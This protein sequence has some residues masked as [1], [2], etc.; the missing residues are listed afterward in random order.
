MALLFTATIA[1]REPSFQARRWQHRGGAA[2][3][4]R[5]DQRYPGAAAT[6][7]GPGAGGGAACLCGRS[8]M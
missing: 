6:A 1:L 4:R 3:P 5:L 8:A 2:A 7:G